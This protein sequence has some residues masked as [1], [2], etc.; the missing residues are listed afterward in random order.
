MTAVSVISPP[1]HQKR[2]IVTSETAPPPP[3]DE[4]LVSPLVHVVVLVVGPPA[5]LLR[6]H[7]NVTGSGKTTLSVSA[8]SNGRP[9]RRFVWRSRVASADS[10]DEGPRRDCRRRRAR[11]LGHGREPR[12]VLTCLEERQGGERSRGWRSEPPRPTALGEARR[13]VG[14]AGRLGARPAVVGAAVRQDVSLRRDAGRALAR[15][16]RRDR[17]PRRRAPRRGG[18]GVAGDEPPQ[19]PGGASGAAGR[20]RGRTPLARG[21]RGGRR[22]AE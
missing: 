19:R 13:L 22:Q 21:G 8:S 16:V 6:C 1:K 17:E 5:A 7:Q 15:G 14:G 18:G 2:A 3:N 11:D 9:P 20:R 4:N 10:A 12:T